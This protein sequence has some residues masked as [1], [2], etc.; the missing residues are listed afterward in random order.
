MSVE[1]EPESSLSDDTAQLI[2]HF[3]QEALTNV[4]RHARADRVIIRVAEDEVAVSDNGMGNDHQAGFGLDSMREKAHSLGA[5]ID[6]APH[7]G[8]DGGFRLTLKLPKERA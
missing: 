5:R 2:L 8:I 3:V 6:T 7:G 4:V 1:G